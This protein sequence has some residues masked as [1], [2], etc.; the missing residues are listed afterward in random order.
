MK[1]T[2]IIAVL[3]C[4]FISA[5][6]GISRDTKQKVASL[7]PKVKRTV[8]GLQ[9]QVSTFAVLFVCLYTHVCLTGK[10]LC[11]KKSY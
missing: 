10:I 5:F 2:G 8:L 1:F 3:I 7:D 6:A 4:L 9:T 11:G